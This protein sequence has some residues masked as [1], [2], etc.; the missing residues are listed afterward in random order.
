M[1]ADTIGIEQIGR[2]LLCVMH[3]C[4]GREADPLLECIKG[5]VVLWFDH[6]CL[7]IHDQ[8]DA[9]LRSAWNLTKARIKPEGKLMW[10]RAN[11]LMSNVLATLCV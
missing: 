11:G 7:K 8:K 3:F 6:V 5:T 9:E 2:C 10:N 4:F 1:A